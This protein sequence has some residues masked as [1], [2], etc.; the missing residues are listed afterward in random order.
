M[1]PNGHMPYAFHAREE[2]AWDFS[3]WRPP[4]HHCPRHHLGVE[5]PCRFLHDK[6]SA[7]YRYFDQKVKEFEAALPAG[8]NLRSVESLNQDPRLLCVY[9][10]PQYT[11]TANQI[12]AN[13]ITGNPISYPTGASFPPDSQSIIFCNSCS[14]AS[15]ASRCCLSAPAAVPGRSPPPARRSRAPRCG[16]PPVA[17]GFWARR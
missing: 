6:S 15:D 13:Q 4:L 3:A 1:S 10:S 7:L 16:R 5:P 2:F 14:S 12:T 11:V 8:V 17:V 9:Y